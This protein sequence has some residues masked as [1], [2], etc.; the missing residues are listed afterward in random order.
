MANGQASGAGPSVLVGN[1][2]SSFLAGGNGDDLIIA[3]PMQWTAEL[4][5]LNE[6]GAS[7]MATLSLGENDL[8]VQIAAIGLEPGQPHAMHLH[9]LAEASGLPLDSQPGSPALDAD[10][11]GFVELAEGRVAQGPPILTLGTPIAAADGSLTFD[12]TFNLDSSQGFASGTDSADLFPLDFRLVEM[13]GLTVGA[14]GAA[15]EGEVDGIAGFKATLPVASG[16]IEA[17]IAAADPTQDGLLLAGGNG[18]DRLIGGQAADLLVGGNGQDVLAGGPGDDDLVGGR[19]ADRFIV[20]EGKDAISDFQ[21]AQ[22]DRIDFG[23]V[24]FGDLVA[25]QTNQG[26]WITVGDAPLSDPDTDGV[27]LVS[28][29]VTS[30]AQVADWLV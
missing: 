20:G 29:R 6:S 24:E 9:G 30:A 16:G 11:D 2:D 25:R 17:A 8:R 15:T 3:A 1:S 4:L 27:L 5:P 28:V 26:L 12:Q 13:H 19:G 23:A 22:G 21:P 7:G 10:G 14:V 18:N